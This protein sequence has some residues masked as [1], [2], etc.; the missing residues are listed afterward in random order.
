MA[1]A[2]PSSPGRRDLNTAT[3][4]MEIN[5]LKDEKVGVNDDGV[6]VRRTTMSNGNVRE[7]QVFKGDHP[8]AKPFPI[9]KAEVKG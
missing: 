3:S 9:E 1:N 5:I 2:N 7:T 6:V 4:G 8:D